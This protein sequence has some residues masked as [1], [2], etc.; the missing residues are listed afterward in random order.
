MSKKI[1][2][3]QIRSVLSG[4]NKGIYERAEVVAMSPFSSLTVNWHFIDLCNMKCR[5]CFADKSCNSRIFDYKSVLDKC[6]IFERVNFVGGEPTIAPQ[7]T[8]MVDYALSLGLK[9][10]VVTNGYHAM[11]NPE[12]FQT[13]SKM[14]TVG[15]SVDSLS[16]K[17]NLQIG[18]SVGNTTLS[19]EDAI[20]FCQRIKSM[21]VELKINTVVNQ[22]NLYED[23]S[24]FLST[25]QPDRWKIFQVIT[26]VD[27]KDIDKEFGITSQEFQ[28][29]ISRH[30]EF[31]NIM[32]IES[33]DLIRN[34]YI[35][36]NAKG[37][38]MG[39]APYT[40]RPHQKSLYDKD[41]NIV[42]EFKKM[43][44]DLTKYHQRYKK[45][46]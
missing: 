14:V 8:E 3:T 33:S 17:I 9:T 24:E 38:F 30:E 31:K 6:Q 32:C 25:V 22:Y 11:K 12:L 41:T 5:F 28:T 7:F 34:S 26:S 29:F 36:I 43:S 16:H 45:I 37:F 42:E 2:S 19:K 44:Y 35:M 21:G 13:F 27:K 39:T 46:G 1:T 40:V 10:S 23:F 15:L 4:L 20:T 18:R